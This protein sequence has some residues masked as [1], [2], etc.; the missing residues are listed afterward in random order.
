M[1]SLDT[2]N[3]ILI[4]EPWFAYAYKEKNKS[5]KIQIHNG[6]STNL[7]RKLDIK[8]KKDSVWCLL[9]NI[10]LGKDS[11]YFKTHRCSLF[12]DKEQYEIGDTISGILHYQGLEWKYKNNWIKFKTY[13][14][15]IVGSSS[16]PLDYIN[17]YPKCEGLLDEAGFGKKRNIIISSP[18]KKKIR[19]I[20][21]L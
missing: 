11:F 14:R 17:T 5:I 6:L 1:Y 4:F 15:C 19:Q 8:F 21:K 18:K 10:K 12:L 16:N 7:Y 13:F 3:R 20:K 9:R 2:S